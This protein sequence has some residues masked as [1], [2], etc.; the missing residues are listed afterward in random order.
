LAA[1][2]GDAE[3]ELH[4]VESHSRPHVARDLAV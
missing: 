3:L 4:F 1:L 2:G